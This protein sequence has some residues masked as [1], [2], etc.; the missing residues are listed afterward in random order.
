MYI[1]APFS[2][3]SSS[4]FSRKSWNFFA[5]SLPTFDTSA[6]PRASLT[7]PDDT[8]LWNRSNRLFVDLCSAK[9]RAKLDSTLPLLCFL[10]SALIVFRSAKNPTAYT[11]AG[12]VMGWR[13]LTCPL[14][15]IRRSY[16]HV[17]FSQQTKV[18]DLA[19]DFAI[20]TTK[21]TSILTRA[22]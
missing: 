2:T 14:V 7:S 21:S 6:S 16:L 19:V 5:L 22:D 8:P 11:C 4:M 12:M 10:C 17:P 9:S 18:M 3:L 1:S 20:S 13:R 15:E